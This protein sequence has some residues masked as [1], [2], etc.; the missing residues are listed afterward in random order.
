VIAEPKVVQTVVRRE[1][2]MKAGAVVVVVH[3]PVE[4]G[5]GDWADERLMV[6]VQE[7]RGA[8]MTF[9]NLYLGTWSVAIRSVG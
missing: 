5:E 4:E 7:A 6:G 8:G 1:V 3:R 2:E 9:D